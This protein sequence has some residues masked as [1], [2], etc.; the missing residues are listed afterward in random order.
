[1]TA[2]PATANDKRIHSLFPLRIL[3]IKS[4]PL[5]LILLPVSQSKLSSILCLSPFSLAPDPDQLVKIRRSS[6]GYSLLPFIPDDGAPCLGRC[7]CCC[8]C[9]SKVPFVRAAAA[10]NIIHSQ[11]QETRLPVSSAGL[12]SLPLIHPAPSCVLPVLVVF[13]RRRHRFPFPAH[14]L[15]GHCWLPKLSNAMLPLLLLLCSMTFRLQQQQGR[16]PLLPA[17]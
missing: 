4:I 3:V 17:A 16:L 11:Q 13:P 1:M 8:Y 15:T 2:E 12:P 9:K 10:K 7:C 5:T 6:V 14:S